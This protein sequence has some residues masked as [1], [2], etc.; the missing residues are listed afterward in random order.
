MVVERLLTAE[1]A[2]EIARTLPVVVPDEGSDNVAGVADGEPEG[3]ARCQRV[4]EGRIDAVVQQE[5]HG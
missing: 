2:G 3:P 5:P 4:V 1:V